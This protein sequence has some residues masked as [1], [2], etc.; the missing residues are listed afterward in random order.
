MRRLRLI[1]LW[2]LLM[3]V[4]LFLLGG[5][6]VTNCHPKIQPNTEIRAGISMTELSQWQTLMMFSPFIKCEVE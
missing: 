6:A 4:S 5:C 3:C 2:L 1:L